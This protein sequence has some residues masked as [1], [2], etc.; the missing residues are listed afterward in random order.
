MAEVV[1]SSPIVCS[2][3]N[4][5]SP[6]RVIF[7]IFWYTY[8][9]FIPPGENIIETKKCRITGEEF[10]VTDRDL[11]FYDT[12]SPVFAGQKCAIP[13]PTLCPRERQ[14]RRMV[15]RNHD[16]LYKN[17]CALTGKEIIST[18]KPGTPYKVA[19]L[20][21]W[22]SDSWNPCD[23][24][25]KIDFSRPFF[26]QFLALDQL[27]IHIP[28]SVLK[29]ENSNFTNFSIQ[30]RN[31]Y[32]CSRIAEAED[33][34]YSYLVV[35]SKHCFDC[36]DVSDSEYLYEC[37][38]TQKSYHSFYCTDSENCHD[39]YF[40]KDCSGCR[41]CFGSCNLRNAQ[42]VFNNKQL[43][44]SEYRNLLAKA[45]WD[46]S[47]PG[48]M[49]DDFLNFCKKFPKKYITGF[50]NEDVSG[51]FLFSNAHI[52]FGFECHECE[53]IRHSYG[54]VHG[55]DCMEWSFGYF[56]E[57]SL[58]FCGVATSYGIRFSVNCVSESRD[59]FYSKDC[60][61]GTKD[62]FWCISLK[63][64]KNC[65][66][67]TAYS[68]QEYEQIAI[69]LINHMRSTGEWGEFFPVE[70]SPY[71]YNE[72]PAQDYFPQD[73]ESIQRKGWSWLE[74][75]KRTDVQGFVPLPIEQYDE[76]KV[77]YEQAQLNID[78]LLATTISCT[79]TGKGYKILPQELAFYIANSLPVPSLH[80]FARSAIRTQQILPPELYNRTCDECWQPFLTSYAPD[81]PEKI[82]CEN[83]YRK[84]VY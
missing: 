55:R 39:C 65:I 3:W 71:A 2:I 64:G 66:L 38:R 32:L 80:P 7:C 14:I 31:C 62:C 33:C 9:M 72:T 21:S 83:C 10:V 76:K 42:F 25:Q 45:L 74:T 35:R 56:A 73:K 51:N 16:Q 19:S 36:R 22:W 4:S 49:R 29:S 15:W 53:N 26:D 47:Q 57:K 11:E 82:L 18:Y 61:N 17:T 52:V 77:G 44:E 70:H 75:D 60:M 23:Y 27:T 58:E 41:D 40:L 20:E 13:S 34:Y 79:Q 54:A 67:N 68:Q 5:K 37:I 30:N 48:K 12:L 78:T 43:Q 84:L 50:N 63:K 81:R 28:V 46:F 69:K 1:G 24:G 8:S 6:E 59:L